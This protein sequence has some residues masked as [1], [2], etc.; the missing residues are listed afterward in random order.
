[1]AYRKIGTGI[2]QDPWFEELTPNA[3]LLFVYLFTND[4]C[5]QSGMYQ[6]SMRR[7]KFESGIDVEVV[8]KE[9]T[10]K[11]SWDADYQ[12]IWVK[13][14]VKWQCQ[15]SNFL[16]GALKSI[17]GIPLDL[18]QQFIKYNHSL[19]ASYGINPTEYRMDTIS[20]RSQNHI[21]TVA[22]SVQ[23]RT[24]TE[25]EADKDTISS[26]QKRTGKYPP[27]SL[28]DVTQ[29]FSNNEYTKESAQKAFDYYE[30]GKTSKGNW[31][32]SQGNIVKNWKQKMR[33]VWFKPEN[34]ALSNGNPLMECQE[35]TR[36]CFKSEVDREEGKCMICNK[37]VEWKEIEGYGGSK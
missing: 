17:N 32:D 28:D 16:I 1:M 36:Q 30:A 13:N 12:I 26:S 6:I 4:V 11:V 2:W 20:V 8:L 21:N 31:T 15:N 35:C 29:Y 9:L 34:K 33:S 19:I 10:G 5:N 7:M 27:P 23:N 22:E 3:K 24:D 25:A 37:K 18:Y 14:F